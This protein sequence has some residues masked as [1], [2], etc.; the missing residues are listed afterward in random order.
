MAHKVFTQ[1]LGFG[2]LLSESIN[3]VKD[4]FKILTIF[5]LVFQLP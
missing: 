1:E 3:I 5:S 4:K 2:E